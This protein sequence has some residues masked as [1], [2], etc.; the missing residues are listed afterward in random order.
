LAENGPLQTL[1]R[2]T[3]PILP[4][5]NG[6][7]YSQKPVVDNNSDNAEPTLRSPG[8]WFYDIPNQRFV[9]ADQLGIG[10]SVLPNRIGMFLHASPNHLIA[11]TYVG[12]YGTLRSNVSPVCNCN[13]MVMTLAYPTD[14]R[15]YCEQK[16]SGA[17]PEDGVLEIDAS[18]CQLWWL[19]PGTF[20]DVDKDGHPILS[21]SSD[22]GGAGTIVRNDWAR[23]EAKMSGA[24]ARYFQERSRAQI[25]VRGLRP[26]S[27][28]LGQILTVI[29]EGGSA[30]T[31]EA[32]ITN[33]RWTNGDNP[34]TII[35]TGFAGW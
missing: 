25:T 3:L 31:I 9:A 33:I 10:V 12:N 29:D 14:Q 15:I 6:V 8:A 21:P 35:S 20:L 2:S 23:L 30:Q 11:P 27:G 28:L 32:P 7:D 13:E 26:W 16:I 4:L 34:T 24:L 17:K 5:E 22:Y 18:E 1:T 19:A